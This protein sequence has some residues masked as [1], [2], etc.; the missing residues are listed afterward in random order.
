MRRF[1]P[2]IVT[3]TL[4]L[5]AIALLLFVPNQPDPLRLAE[6][7]LAAVGA[8]ISVLLL[9]RTVA[10]PGQEGRGLWVSLLLGATLVP[11]LVIALQGI[12][13]A[14]GYTLVAPFAVAGTELLDSLRADPGL[15]QV[16][17]SFWAYILIVDLAI[18]APLAE[19]T[20]KPLGS[21]FRRPATARDAFLFGAAAGTG[22]AV[23]ENVMYAGGWFF[24]LDY[25][26]PISVTRILG[27]GLHAF[28]AALVSW[29]IFQWRQRE[30]GRW[31]RL[32]R[33]YGI[34]FATHALWN[35]TIA[36]TQVLYA[37]RSELGGSLSNDALAWGVSLQAFLG[38]LGALI[39]AA[40]L[41]S[42]KRIRQER[43]P[44]H[45]DLMADL[46][47]PVGIASWAMISTALLIPSAIMV[48]VFPGLVAL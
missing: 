36:V 11:V 27:A 35:G 20:T 17:T 4:T 9:L 10:D 26:L 2:P 15:A 29:G 24:N 7:L 46:G 47:R 19:E 1:Q 12:F 6:L 38:V 41:L 18:I 8:P 48:L 30:A 13:L 28:G 14:I 45:L 43:E 37:G 44:I 16:L 32:G 42:G 22:F 25:W 34:A 23:V 33:A 31:R 3:G 40:L 5:L 39:A 21:L